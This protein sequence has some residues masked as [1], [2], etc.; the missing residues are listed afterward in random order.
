MRGLAK[1]TPRPISHSSCV[2]C[3]IAHLRKPHGRWLTGPYCRLCT[4]SGR[5][6]NADLSE[7]VECNE[8]ETE[9]VIGFVCGALAVVTVAS[10]L[11]WFRPDRKIKWLA[12]RLGSLDTQISLRAKC[13]IV[14]RLEHI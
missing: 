10:L 1:R 6:Y 7:C 11:A 9:T 2:L 12:I 8:N 5:Y 4:V 3:A 14:F 13:A